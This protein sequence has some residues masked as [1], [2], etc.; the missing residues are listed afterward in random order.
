M[1][2]EANAFSAGNNRACSNGR[3]RKN[4]YGNGKRA[5]T[6]DRGSLQKRLLY[7]RSEWR[8]NLLCLQRIQAHDLTL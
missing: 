6:R 3:S 2:E 8:K 5:G 1:A 7:Y 4:K